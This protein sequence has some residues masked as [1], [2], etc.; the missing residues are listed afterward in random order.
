MTFTRIIS[1]LVLTASCAVAET[2]VR[3]SGASQRN[4]HEI[5]ELLGDR[6]SHVKASPPSA[7]LADDAAFMLRLML[8]KDG[9]AGATVEWKITGREEITLRVNEGHRSKLGEVKIDGVPA[10]D[11]K[12]LAG[13]YAKPAL[14]GKGVGMEKAPFREVDVATGVS[15][16]QQEL[17][18]RG[19]WNAEV[20]FAS[21]HE[22]PSSGAVDI[23]LKVKLGPQ[24]RIA[25]PRAECKEA[26]AVQRIA[27]S[28]A[29][30]VGQI[31]TSGQLNAMRLAVETSVRAQGYPQAEIRME[32]TLESARFIP[33]F[34]VAL[35][36][37]VKLHKILIAGLKKT[38]LYRVERRLKPLE[39]DWY[40]EAALNKRLGSLLSTGAFSSVRVE[41]TASGP[42]GLDAMVMFEEGKAREFS[43]GAGF[44]SYQGVIL[45]GNYSDRNLFGDLLGFSAGLEVGSRGLLGDARITDPWLFGSDISM[46]LRTYALIYRREG[47]D[48]YETGME[49]KFTW[50]YG[51]HYTLDL[52]AGWSI[53]NATATD[54]PSWLIGDNSYTHPR[55]RLSQS[56]DFRDNPILPTSGWHIDSYLQSGAAIG[57]GTSSYFM[58]GV[59]GGWHHEL[60]RKFSLGIGGEFTHVSPSG[61]PVDLPIDLRVFNGGARTVRSFPERELGPTVDGYA[62]GGETAWSTNFE[63]IRK[64]TDSLSGVSF[65]DVGSISGGDI[66]IADADVEVAVGLGVRLNLPIGPVRLEYGY[67]LTRDGSDPTGAFHFAIG[68]AF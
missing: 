44:G 18:S 23:S 11:V 41:P 42:D 25:A 45:R 51:K 12:K 28:A 14:S 55:I 50:K 61:D 40:D 58:A 66:G 22:D 10:E 38:K 53:V 67:N 47:Y 2:R 8:V 56:I 35:G 17:F 57:D 31:A 68:A 26:A 15:Y 16:V 64:I 46:T 43:L 52:L 36:E 49:D 19:Y 7:P 37:R 59:S 24:F 60:G 65:V 5:L 6:I 62:Y 63:V 48:T 1:Y 54:L 29:P 39:G 33:S 27:A 30:F 21:K 20:A 3:V 9:Y 34:Y 4:E 32:R 13:I